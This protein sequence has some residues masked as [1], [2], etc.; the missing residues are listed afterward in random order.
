VNALEVLH[1]FLAYGCLGMLLEVFFTG[2]G[3]LLHKNWRAT[4]QTYLWMLPIYG[5]AGLALQGIHLSLL[6][7]W[8]PLAFVYLVTIYA[9]EFTSGWLLEKLIGRCPW[10]YGLSAWTPL[11]LINLRYAPFWFILGCFFNPIASFLE[12]AVRLLGSV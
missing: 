8:F 6:W 5:L 4:C 1:Q 3:S 2:I 12:R 10:H 7:H 11:G 9:I